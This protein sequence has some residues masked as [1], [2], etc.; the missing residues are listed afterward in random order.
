M[1][2]IQLILKATNYNFKW[3]LMLLAVTLFN[4]LSPCVITQ[5]VYLS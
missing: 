4:H 1:F 2:I 5:A 3:A